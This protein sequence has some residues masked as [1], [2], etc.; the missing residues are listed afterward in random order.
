MQPIPITVRKEFEI[1]LNNKN[2]SGRSHGFYKK[3]LQYY[4][5]F[6]QKYNFQPKHQVKGTGK[7]FLTNL[8][9]HIIGLTHEAYLLIFSP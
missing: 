1:H 2:I 9:V 4:L 8:S 5:D 3:W 6:C 7:L